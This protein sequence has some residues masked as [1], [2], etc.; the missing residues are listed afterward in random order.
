M[1]DICLNSNVN[2]DQKR[3]NLNLRELETVLF[4]YGGSIDISPLMIFL[5]YLHQN[6][7]PN[8]YSSQFWLLGNHN[9]LPDLELSADQQLKVPCVRSCLHTVIVLQLQVPSNPEC[10]AFCP[11]KSLDPIF[12]GRT[13]VQP[14]LFNV[15]PSKRMLRIFMLWRFV[16]FFSDQKG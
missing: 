9:C 2:Q 5:H 11:K 1:A 3:I 4:F 16:T 14:P 13:A 7:G 8:Y 10:C 6:P 12:C 15:L